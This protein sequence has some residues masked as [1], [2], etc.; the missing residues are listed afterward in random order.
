MKCLG[1]TG[2]A[3]ESCFR[4]KLM[5]WLEFRLEDGRDSGARLVSAVSYSTLINPAVDALQRMPSSVKN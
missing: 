1:T 3:K 2:S 4:N 5:C